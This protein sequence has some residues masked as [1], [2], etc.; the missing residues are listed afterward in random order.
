MK[1]IEGERDESRTL[2]A[3]AKDSD[4]QNRWRAMLVSG[5]DLKVGISTE[6]CT[7]SP[8]RQA[9]KDSLYP[10]RTIREFSISYSEVHIQGQIPKNSVNDG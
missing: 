9:Q 5:M 8:G 4:D 6:V 2:M 10:N 3:G 1:G 7:K